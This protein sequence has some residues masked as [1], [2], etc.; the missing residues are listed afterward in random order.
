MS[1]LTRSLRRAVAGALATLLPSIATAQ[2]SVNECVD[3]HERGQ[4]LARDGRLIDADAAFRR[5]A[6]DACPAVVRSECGELRANVATTIPTIIVG[7]HL[8]A[9]ANAQDVADAALWIDGTRVADRLDGRPR[10]LDPGEH[11]VQVIA[12]GAQPAERR[13]VVRAAEKDRLLTFELV[14]IAVA[15]PL[16]AARPPRRRTGALVASGVGFAAMA[17]FATFGLLGRSKQAQLDGCKPGCERRDVDEMRKRYLI[18]DASLAASLV[19]FAAAAW[20][21]TGRDGDTMVALTPGGLSLN[22]RF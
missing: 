18:A 1:A 13:I 19:A 17:S 8:G 12:P 15:S 16:P 9:R 10:A 6:D 5:C 22:G 7:A 2:P 4:R 14:P 3:A 20:L 21:W 11:A